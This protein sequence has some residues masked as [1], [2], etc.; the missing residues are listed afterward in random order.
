M[1]LIISNA[2]LHI[3]NNN[4]ADSCFSSQ[5]LDIDSETCFEF[6]GKHVRRLLNN[7]GAKDATFTAESS[8]YALVKAY[9]KGEIHFKEMSL[10]ICERLERI[11]KDNQDIP[12][13]DILVAAFD[14][15]DKRYLAVLKLGYG[16]CFTHQV[17]EGDGGAENHIV[18]NTVVLPSS[19]AKVEEACL[20]PFDPMVLR[21]LEKPHLVDSQQVDYFSEMFLE[22][23][24]Q[25]SKKMT[26]DLIRE[27]TDEINVKYYNDDVEMAAKVK[28]ALIDEAEQSQEE[29][30]L[31]L[32][33]VARKVFQ[34]NEEV[35]SKF[36]AMTKD[37]GLPHEVRLDKSFV[38]REFK[39]Q[40]FKADNGIELKLPAELFQDPE[41][42]QFT[43][44]SDGTVSITLKNLRRY[45]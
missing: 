40:K 30:T 27:I 14:N 7:P 1:A 33:N 43:Q 2:I 29:E 19:G 23:E 39:M 6:I 15:G 16:E 8:V 25:I 45:A 11:M 21:I 24:T 12:P 34:E 32:E 9:Q 20:I 26:A 3:I 17:V 13:S 37:V 35:C 4:G 36:I 22:C 31:N 44:N 41:T 38:Q 5:E 28:C 18:K 10:H 42:I